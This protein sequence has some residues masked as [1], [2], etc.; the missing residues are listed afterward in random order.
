MA[1][2]K[3]PVLDF[4]I[5]GVFGVPIGLL[6]AML[7]PGLVF[8]TTKPG[9]FLDGTWFFGSA[10]LFSLTLGCSSWIV[11]S[12]EIPRGRIVSALFGGIL[13]AALVGT[14]ISIWFANAHENYWKTKAKYGDFFEWIP[15][16]SYA[17]FLTGLITFMVDLALIAFRSRD[18]SA[19]QIGGGQ[20]ATRSESK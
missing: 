1:L 16:F 7:I 14:L 11:K 18:S 15:L 3:Q 5:Y 9:H 20:P 6:T 19:E 10:V 13:A 8:H 17:I 12:R 4:L 2:Q